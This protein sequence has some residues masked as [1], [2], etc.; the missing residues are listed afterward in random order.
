VTAKVDAKAVKNG[1]LLDLR[2]L[3]L[4]S[5]TLTV[6]ATDRA[7]NKT[8]KSVTFKIKAT[9]KSLIRSVNLYYDDHKITSASLKNRL[10]S[11]LNA[12]ESYR[13]H[14]KYRSA[15][16]LLSSFQMTVGSESGKRINSGAA[17][18]LM[19][20]ASYVMSNIRN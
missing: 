2:T 14:S 15:R 10:L 19:D 6:T 7:G 20:D 13:V 17:R 16:I 18:V 12:A 1:Q 8:T 4:G 11:L 9:V 5:H 3:K